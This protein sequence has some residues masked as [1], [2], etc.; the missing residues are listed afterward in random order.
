MEAT[1][2]GGAADLKARG[3]AAFKAGEI[4]AAIALYSEVRP[5]CRVTALLAATRRCGAL[6][7]AP[8]PPSWSR[9]AVR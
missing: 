9:S 2:L 5:P 8:S 4:E 3:N 6:T 7:R 1:S